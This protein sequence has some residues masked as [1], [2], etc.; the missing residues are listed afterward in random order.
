MDLGEHDVFVNVIGGLRLKDPTAD[1]AV[2]TA[3]ATA[4]RDIV[5]KD[6]A[7]W[8]EIGLGGE[9]RPVSATDRRLSEASQLGFKKIVA[10]L[11]NKKN[12][13]IP[14]GIEVVDARTLREAMSALMK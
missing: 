6:T 10:P 11:P 14:S 2:V 1:L 5:L 7:V 3:L 12:F 9:L 8:G 13:K 4:H